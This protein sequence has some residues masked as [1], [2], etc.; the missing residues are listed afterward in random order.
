VLIKRTREAKFTHEKNHKENIPVSD[1]MSEDTS[2]HGASKVEAVSKHI[3]GARKFTFSLHYAPRS[4]SGEIVLTK[5]C[6]EDHMIDSY[7]DA[8]DALNEEIS[9]P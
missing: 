9:S 6:I 1:S 4:L 8:F 2:H 3:P 5:T 7:Q